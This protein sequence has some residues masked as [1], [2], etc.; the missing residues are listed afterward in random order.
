MSS[1]DCFC[2]A[3]LGVG[4]LCTAISKLPRGLVQLSVS[5]T[6]LGSRSIGRIAETLQALPSIYSTLRRLDLSHNSVRGEEIAVSF[7]GLF[8]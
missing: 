5:R 6:G 3:G 7:V 2:V 1:V 8:R 4:Q